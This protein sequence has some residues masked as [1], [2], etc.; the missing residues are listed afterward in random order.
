MDVKEQR[1]LSTFVA[2]STLQTDSRLRELTR[3][4]PNLLVPAAAT[5]LLFLVAFAL[6]ADNQHPVLRVR[7]SPA[8]ADIRAV[9]PLLAAVAS[10]LAV[11][12]PWP[13]LVAILALTPV[14]NSANVSF[15]VGPIQIILQTLFAAVL[16]GGCALDAVTKRRLAGRPLAYPNRPTDADAALP[17]MPARSAVQRRRLSGIE[18]V[19]LLELAVVAFVALAVGSTVASLN[20]GNSANGLL[21][22]IVEPVLFGLV[23]VWLRPSPRGLLTIAGA[24]A[25]SIGLASLIDILQN[26]WAYGTNITQ[27]VNHRLDFT[28]ATYN[29]VG[30]FG[31]IIATV[32]PMLAA[33]LLLR[34][35]LSLPRWGLVVL[36]VAAP[37]SMAG[38]FFTVSKSAW[39]ASAAALVLL[40]LLLMH[41]WWKRLSMSIA[42]IALSAIFIPWPALVLQSIPSM[43]TA[44]RKVIVAMVGQQRFDSWN[45]TTLSGHGSMAERYYAVQGGVDMAIDHPILGVGLNEFHTYYMTLGYR[46]D[47]AKDDLDHAH[48]VFPEVAAELGF[49]AL[50]MLL[51]VFG[52]ALWAMWKVY[53]AAH[54]NISRTM[55]AMLIASVTAWIVAGTAYGA[56]IYRAFRDQSSDIVAL[57]VVIGMVVALARWARDTRGITGMQGFV[58]RGVARP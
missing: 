52:A 19:R 14:W 34:R 4:L 17:E 44:Y 6:A 7:T 42:V 10:V 12:R 8:A 30:L 48:S 18:S 24:L 26:Y 51:T 54:D 45:P 49:P 25:V 41:T 3:T 38:L 31:V 58:R 32:L 29:N 57:A 53:R 15:D 11:Y 36:L 21:H 16:I 22:G 46:S 43:D 47:Q 9:V 37:L 33:G 27:I 1:R 5:T 39:L 55:A 28:Q 23:L 50:A 13:A 20:P 56:D 2:P 40:L 35:E